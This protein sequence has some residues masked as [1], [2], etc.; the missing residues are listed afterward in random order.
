MVELSVLKNMRR[1]FNEN[2]EQYVKEHPGEF[3]VFDGPASNIIFYKT[4]LEAINY[5]KKYSRDN[6]ATY[7]I[8]KIPR[9]L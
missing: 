2:L 6:G 9:W 5:L 8:E 4:E 7:L 1:V 3:V